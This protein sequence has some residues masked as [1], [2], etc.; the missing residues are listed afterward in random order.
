[1]TKISATIITLNEERNIERCILSLEGVADEIIVLDSFST[2]KT[3]EICRKLG[4][5]FEKRA[6]E[7]YSQS[8]NYL[9]ALA[10]FDYIFSIDADEALSEELKTSILAEKQ[11]G[12]TGVY[13]VNRMTNYLGKWIKHSGWYPDVKTRIFPKASSK[14]VGAY[15]H[16]EL[17]VEGN[18]T[19]VLLKGDLHHYS[20]YSFEDHRSRADKYSRLTAQKMNVK[21]KRASILKPYLS[22][23]VRFVGMYFIKLG[24]LDGKM[25]FKI[26]QISALSNIYKYKELRRLNREQNNKS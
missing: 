7:G 17:E 21:G 8:K 22:A 14:W 10:S 3:E 24:F 9:N 12:L 16:E 26:A 20:Y 2:D 4:V 15:V 18:P 11:K 5:R 6:W 23:L 19:P 25:G 13:A 1:M